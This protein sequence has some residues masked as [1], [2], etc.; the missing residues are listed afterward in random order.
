MKRNES[1]TVLLVEDEAI[2]A[3]AEAKTLERHG[4]AVLTALSG[5]KAIET[6]AGHPDIDLILMDID[7]GHGMDGTQA[8][9]TILKTKDIPVVFLSNHT[10]PEIV[11][12]TEKITSYGY[13]VKNSGDTVLLASIRMAFKLHDAH[14]ELRKREDD[15]KKSQKILSLIFDNTPNAIT[16][17]DVETNIVIEANK[18]IEWTGWTRDEIVG[19]KPIM[20]ENWIGPDK[21]TEIREILKVTGKLSNYRVEFFKKDGTIAHAIMNSV[22]I[23]ID[24]RPH[25]LTI[26]N[27]VTR[28]SVSETLFRRTKEELEMTN[29]ELNATVKELEATNEELQTTITELEETKKEL[30]H[31][32][33]ERKKIEEAI[34]K[35]EER[36][37]TIFEKSATANCIMA[38]DL[39]ILLVNSNFEKLTGYSRDELEGRM[40]A[41]I[42]VTEE[43]LM[44]MK[45]YHYQRMTDPDLPPTAYEFKGRIR[46]GEIKDFFMSVALIPGTTDSILSIIDITKNK[47]A[48]E[49]LKHNEERFSDFARFLPATVF[50]TDMQGRI[51]YVNQFALELFGYSLEEVSREMTFLDIII[52]SDHNRIIG[53]IGKITEGERLGLNDYTARKKDGTTFPVL[54]HSSRIIRNGQP[55]GVRGVLVDITDRKRAEEIITRERDFSRAAIDSMPGLFYLFDDK[56]KFIRWN[57]NFNIVSGYSDEEI[58]GRTPLSYFNGPDRTLIE[59]RITE[60]FLTGESSAEAN[61]ISRDGT[62]RPYFF[63]GRVMMFEGKP[64]LIGMGIDITERKRVEEALQQER[65]FTDAVLDSVPGLLYMY[66]EEWRLRRWNKN[67][68]T[69]TGYTAEELYGMHVLDWFK[70]D[71]K[72]E[73]EIKAGVEK[74]FTEGHATAEASLMMKS[75]SKIPYYFTATLLEIQGRKYFTGIGIDISERKRAEDA[76]G[77]ALR[78]KDALLQELQHRMKNSLAMITGIIELEAVRTD[79]AGEKTVLNNLKGRI[80]SLTN[81][82]ALLFQTNMVTEVALDE[83]IQSI[84]SSLTATYVDGMSTIRIDRQCDPLTVSVKNAT[85]WGLIVNELLT[86]A[87]KYAFP[88]DGSGVI[89]ISLKMADSEASLSVSDNGAGPPPDFNID[90]PAGFGLLL[91]NMLTRQLGGALSFTRGTENVFTVRAPARS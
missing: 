23:Q 87:L 25:F 89:R 86:N 15:L 63:S 67:H 6:A 54:V 12:K 2:T 59:E 13:V 8:A 4:Y 56:G 47:Q 55:I 82:Y 60:T 44:K 51:T 76:L 70:H 10:E 38:K 46:S 52:P 45:E 66:D 29:E 91:V 71:P 7:L 53:N 68:E 75:G 43:S 24:D 18:G 65:T 88:G 58:A 20:L 50:E 36:Y 77:N 79:N 11:D 1:K 28:L 74:A 42:F 61:F 34:R 84:V 78:E 41:T 72:D 21:S 9:E 37:R 39:S 83:Y 26:S 30:E 14:R 22:L 32:L 80:D 62:V 16:I 64:C 73:A 49:A 35:S 81:L 17:T 69:F 90:H 19:K 48:E 27:D 5:D 85:A 40:S 31:A 33:A 57:N 3:M